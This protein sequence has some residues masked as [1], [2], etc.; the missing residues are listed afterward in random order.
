[1]RIYNKCSETARKSR[2]AYETYS[3]EKINCRWCFEKLKNSD[4]INS[5]WSIVE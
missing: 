1:M 5:S 2:L 4:F 3:L